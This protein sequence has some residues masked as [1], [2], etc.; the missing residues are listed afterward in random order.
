MA[1]RRRNAVGK[2]AGGKDI[3][4]DIITGLLFVVAV[5]TVSHLAFSSLGF[6]PTDD[7]FILA[8]SR[9]L[10]DGQ[11]PHRDFI[12]VRPAGS[13]L[14]YAPLLYYGGDYAIWLSR[15]AAWMEVAV[16][17]W[18]WT[19]IISRVFNVM[20]PD[21]IRYAF[22]FVAFCLTAHNFPMMAWHSL[23]ALC[24]ASIGL[25]ACSYDTARSSGSLKAAG[26]F[27]LGLSVLFRQNFIIL[28]P[29]ALLLLGDW[30]NIRIWVLAFA[31]AAAYSGCMLLS[32]A[33][34]DAVSQFGVYGIKDGLK[35]AW[36]YMSKYHFWWGV[37]TGYVI[38]L[39]VMKEGKTSKTLGLL[40]IYAAV[41]LALAS[42]DTSIA[43]YCGKAPFV[44]FGMTAGV[45]FNRIARNMPLDKEIRWGSLA[46]LIAFAV[47]L[48]KGYG[49]PAFAAG[50]LAVWLFGFCISHGAREGKRAYTTA[51]TLVLL[52]SSII[53][54]YNERTSNIYRDKPAGS[55]SYDIG[56][57]VR[58]GAFIKTNVNTYK[59]LLDL[60]QLTDN[61][62]A[63]KRRYCILPDLAVE[64]AESPQ[65][66]PL[67]TDWPQN[68][69]LGSKELLDR[70][71]G[72]IWKDRGM[73]VIIVEKYDMGSLPDSPSPLGDG[74]QTVNYVREHFKKTGET[75]YF[76]LYE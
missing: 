26:Y 9:R 50:A 42:M 5:S 71:V 43:E 62:S 75:E 1:G 54:F 32:G 17:A 38:T 28:I 72:A 39:A 67:P 29:A 49:S 65:Q 11:I 12:T 22:A 73:L 30:R 13:Y 3:I 48:S 37:F 46:L 45:I 33:F 2:N 6:N 47:S 66:N 34:G 60:R 44:L 40:G 19:S 24:I 36:E 57:V 52:L 20:K 51:L 25:F 76:E 63:G 15:L 61:L 27:I 70:S 59:M 7:G 16:I 55:L 64:W 68:T 8:G 18:A 41:L 58:G 4:R 35:E 10:L 53:I 56:G 14:L 69:E 74:Y 21:Y 23:D 31:P